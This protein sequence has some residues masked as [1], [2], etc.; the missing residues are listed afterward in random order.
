MSSE[1]AMQHIVGDIAEYLGIKDIEDRDYYDVDYGAEKIRFRVA[2]GDKQ[3][4]TCQLNLRPVSGPGEGREF[5]FHIAADDP[6]KLD[7]GEYNSTPPLISVDWARKNRVEIDYEKDQMFYKDDPSKI[8][9]LT[10]NHCGI[11]MIPLTPQAV[12]KQRIAQ[13]HMNNA[14]QA[15]VDLYTA[16]VENFENRANSSEAPAM[17]ASEATAKRAEDNQP[18]SRRKLRADDK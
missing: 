13:R 18:E 5:E 1:F 8:Y 10:R 3:E 6:K 12:E 15:D 16:A 17:T 4:S 2:N 14:M 11:L 9:K 7:R